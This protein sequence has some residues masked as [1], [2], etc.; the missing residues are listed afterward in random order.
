MH[1]CM[2]HRSFTEPT[3][4]TFDFVLVAQNRETGGGEVVEIMHRRKSLDMGFVLTND[5]CGWLFNLTLCVGDYKHFA[6]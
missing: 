2:Y 1:P 3:H 4:R 5:G 6:P